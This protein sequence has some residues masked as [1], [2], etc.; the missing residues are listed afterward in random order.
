VYLVL[1]LIGFL[2]KVGEAYH[3]DYATS[4][5]AIMYGLVCSLKNEIVKIAPRGRVNCVAPGW[6]K[7]PMAETALADFNIIYQAL[8]TT[9]LRKVAEPK[10]VA[11]QVA[12]I[13]SN[14][15][16]GHVTGEVSDT[17]AS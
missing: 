6:T 11:N 7:T 10:D 3:A 4:K 13:S 5:S 15:V 1:L 12:F 14:K 8:A 2:G 17:S 9:P 16:S